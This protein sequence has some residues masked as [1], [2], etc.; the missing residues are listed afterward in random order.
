VPADEDAV[1]EDAVEV[2]GETGDDG[3]VEVYV[4]NSGDKAKCY[5]IEGALDCEMDDDF[6]T[7]VGKLLFKVKTS[8]GIES[9]GKCNKK[10]KRFN[11][12]KKQGNKKHS[13][14]G[15]GKKNG[16]HKGK[17]KGQHQH[18]KKGENK[19]EHKGEYKGERKG[20]HKGEK[21]EKYD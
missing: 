6:A 14:S 9:Y 13:G 10:G 4:P 12:S 19:G 11:C 7:D 21:E 3:V 18:G 5:D 20:E 17:G 2:I 15:D 8:K 16:G 1:P